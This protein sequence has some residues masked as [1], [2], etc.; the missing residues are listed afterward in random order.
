MPRPEENLLTVVDLEEGWRQLLA[1]KPPPE[2]VEEL[3][4]RPVEFV[5]YVKSRVAEL[6]QRDQAFQKALLLGRLEELLNSIWM[7]KDENPKWAGVVLKCLSE[8]RSII[9]GQAIPVAP[10]SGK[11]GI[12]DI[13]DLERV[14]SVSRTRK[15]RQANRAKKAS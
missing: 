1:G 7:K 3:A 6:S 5:S 11:G 10:G 8:Q 15:E 12:G 2:I 14:S 9:M 4:L 13:I